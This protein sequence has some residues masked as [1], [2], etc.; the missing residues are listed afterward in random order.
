VSVTVDRDLVYV[1][2]AGSDNIA[3][4]QLSNQGK[5]NPLPNAT[6]PLSASGTGPAQIKFSPDGRNL[7]ITEK[8]T[9][10][11]TVYPLNRKGIPDEKP[12]VFASEAPTPFGFTFRWPNV[13]L[14][15]E[16]NGGAANGSS[17]SSYRLN[18]AG[19][20][21]TLAASVP[22]QQ[23]AACWVELTPNQRYAY[24]TN[25]GSGSVSGFSV[26]GSGALDPLSANGITADTGAESAPIDLAFSRSGRFLYTLNSGNQTVSAFRVEFDGSL[27]SVGTIAGL[28]AGANGLVA[29]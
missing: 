12:M 19:E 16:A 26:R 21:Q 13:L 29:R 5:L 24:V 3:G 14:V 17:V 7:V 15:S 27:K 11:L 9:N 28:P 18:R 8:A 6:R 1:V 4:F 22:T 23:S 20:L 10:K 2:N 25:T